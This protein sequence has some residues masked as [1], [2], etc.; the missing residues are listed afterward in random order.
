MQGHR[1]L[2]ELSV[3]KEDLIGA[4]V[5]VDLTIVSPKG[6]ERRE[7]YFGRIK[8]IEPEIGR[9]EGL[10][11][12]SDAD[13]LKVTC[14]DG[15][16]REFPYRGEALDVLDPGEYELPDGSRADNLDYLIS[17]RMVEPAEH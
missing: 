14:N 9:F 15:R 13:V 10:E 1:R 3:A 2:V 7:T 17:W 11:D 6:D 12:G 5:L 4:N 16:E 8:S